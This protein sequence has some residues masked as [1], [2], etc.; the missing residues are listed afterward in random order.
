MGDFMRHHPGQFRLFIGTQHQSAIHVEKAAGQCKSI[1]LVRV[2]HLDS[3]GHF[4]VGIAHQVLANAVDELDHDRIVHQ[5]GGALHFLRQLL[6]DSDLFLEGVEIHTLADVAVADL[7]DVGLRI[8]LLLFFL[9]LRSGKS[10]AESQKGCQY[11][12]EKLLDGSLHKPHLRTTLPIVY[13][14][15]GAV[16]RKSTRLNS[17][18]GY[19]SYAVFCLKKKKRQKELAGV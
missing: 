16:D 1:D 9:F 13:T 3:E 6:A 4:G 18:H 12:S 2:D 8:L 10:R 5:F 7:I 15:Y 14:G 17:S 11:A 19:I